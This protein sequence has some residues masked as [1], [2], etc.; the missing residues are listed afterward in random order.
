[1]C[2]QVESGADLATLG[3]K[4]QDLDTTTLLLLDDSPFT[5]V[6]VTGYLM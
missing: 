2:Y 5:A 3:K 4:H 6:T 1:M